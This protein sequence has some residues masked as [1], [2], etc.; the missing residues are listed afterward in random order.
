MKT[1]IRIRRPPAA[2]TF[3]IPSHED[4]LALRVGD[5]VKLIFVDDEG[6]GERMWVRITDCSDNEKWTGT[7]Q[8]TAV[9]WDLDWG[10]DVVFHP[11]DIIDV[12]PKGA[13]NRTSTLR[14]RGSLFLSHSHSDKEFCKRLADD[15][16]KRG[17]RVWIDEAEMQVGDSLIEKISKA[18]NEMEFVA[19]VLSR[20]SV[21]SHWVRKEVDIAMTQEIKGRRVKVLP[22]L[23]EECEIPS[24]LSDKIYADFRNPV[25]Y[26]SALEKVVKRLTAHH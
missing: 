6:N 5:L 18:I 22:I 13:R 14:R 10:T 21:A 16:V 23:L 11:Y 2:G 20:R 17:V 15:L 8:N 4:I 24:F 9:S 7:L 26:D 3:W 12:N 19:V 1:R 25:N